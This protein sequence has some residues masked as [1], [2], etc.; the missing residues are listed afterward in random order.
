MLS[1]MSW[2][3]RPRAPEV[4]GE[5]VS[6]FIPL[7]ASTPCNPFSPV[8]RDGVLC[9]LQQ[10][11]DVWEERRSSSGPLVGGNGGT[12]SRCR[13][14]VLQRWLNEIQKAGVAGVL[15]PAGGLPVCYEH[16]L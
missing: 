2:L 15:E 10:S 4:R 12:S 5:P 13:F 8:P 6:R 1:G 7:A 3:R 11:G 9:G 16:E 14:V